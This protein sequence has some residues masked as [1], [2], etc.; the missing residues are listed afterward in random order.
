MFFAYALLTHDECT[1]YTHADSMNSDAR[2]HLRSSGVA[3]LQY[4]QIWAHLK[5]WGQQLDEQRQAAGSRPESPQPQAMD[6][7]QKKNKNAR[8]T[9]KAAL[10]TKTSWAVAEALGRVCGFPI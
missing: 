6:E 10:S 2:E 1:V 9:Y 7:D 3:V 8:Q 5:S 4:D